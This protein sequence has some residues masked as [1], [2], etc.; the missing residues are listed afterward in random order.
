MQYRDACLR[1]KHIGTYLRDEELSGYL[2]ILLLSF[3]FIIFGLMVYDLHYDPLEMLM[4][5]LFSVASAVTTTG[6]LEIMTVVV[7]FMPEFWRH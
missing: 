3:M 1:S 4:Q 7:L 6:R 2:I 5:A